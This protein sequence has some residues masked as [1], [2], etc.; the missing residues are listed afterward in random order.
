[1]LA[2]KA[3]EKELVDAA[4]KVKV[5][6]INL[7]KEGNGF[8]FSLRPL[9]RDT[10]RKISPFYNVRRINAVCW[11]GH[12]DFMFAVYE[13]NKEAIFITHPPFIGAS[14]I[15]Y[16]G[17]EDFLVKY[18]RTGLR[19]VGTALFPTNFKDCCKCEE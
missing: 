13:N 12:R 15:I 17:Y 14:R 4:K 11:H 16:D 19:N 7:K 3:T 18:P 2:R 6:I 1:M 10:Y 9:D 5:K 8:R